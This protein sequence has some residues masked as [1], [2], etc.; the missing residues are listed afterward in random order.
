M[1]RIEFHL[2]MHA[3]FCRFELAENSNL[4]G[5]Q[6]ILLQFLDLFTGTQNLET[7]LLKL[8]HRALYV[9]GLSEIKKPT[10]NLSGKI[11]RNLTAE[12]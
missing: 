11:F 9:S 5:S 1:G 2:G 3:C 10:S 8:N 7:Q 4:I 12:V 6:S